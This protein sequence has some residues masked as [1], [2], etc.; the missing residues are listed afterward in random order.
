MGI[1][2]GVTLWGLRLTANFCYHWPGIGHEDWRLQFYRS[3]FLHMKNVPRL[4]TD[5]FGVHLFQTLMVTVCLIPVFDVDSESVTDFGKRFNIIDL[6]AFLVMFCGIII[7]SVADLQLHKFLK[8]KQEGECLNT[9]LW[10]WSRHPNY[11]GELTFWFGIYLFSLATYAGEFWRIVVGLASFVALAC[12]FVFSSIPT[13]E[14]R[15][16]LRRKNYQ[17]VIDSTSMLVMWPPGVKQPW[18]PVAAKYDV[19]EQEE[20]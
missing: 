16:L 9:G 6:I 7:E 18:R 8:T 12:L 3:K 10:A 4:V 1:T 17:D 20:A 2:F 11:F 15:A 19:T 5:F 13:H 14:E